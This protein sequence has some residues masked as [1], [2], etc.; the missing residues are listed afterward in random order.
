MSPSSFSQ[1]QKPIRT[2]IWAGFVIGLLDITAAIINYYI[3]GGREP[4]R[5]FYFI[6]SG[7][8]GKSAFTG[9]TVM[10]IAGLLLHFMIAYIFTIL[11]FLAYPYIRQLSINK[12]IAGLLY[13]I[14]IWMIMNMA[15][16]P[17]SNVPQQPFKLSQAIIG[18][19]ILMLMVGLPV[20]L[21]AHRYYSLRRKM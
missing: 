15:V 2:I 13:G 16:L 20:S 9:G 1:A 14:V 3:T 21:I 10:V 19:I 12:I 18:T 4:V 11:Y 17:L 7:V 6:A 5:I 8:F